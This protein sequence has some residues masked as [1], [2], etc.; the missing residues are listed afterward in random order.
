[1]PDDQEQFA[2]VAMLGAVVF[3]LTDFAGQIIARGRKS[4]LSRRALNDIRKR[5]IT[6]LKN[7]DSSGFPIELEAEVFRN[8]IQQLEN[9]TEQAIARGWER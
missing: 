4:R 9:F 5:C 8:A 7:F 3:S 2:T 6:N 1:M